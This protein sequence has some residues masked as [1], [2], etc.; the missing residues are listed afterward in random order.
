MGKRLVLLGVLVIGAVL[1]SGC[2]VFEQLIDQITGTGDPGGGTPP[3]GGGTPGT[4]G[5]VTSVSINY[6]F[7]VTMSER[8]M[9]TYPVTTS[10]R[11]LVME[12]F[13]PYGGSYDAATKTYTNT[14]DDQVGDFSDTYLEV[15]LNAAEDTIEYFYA[16]QTQENVWG[17][18]TFVN[19]IRG[20]NIPYSYTDSAAA[21]GA[22]YF[23]VTGTD[24]QLSLDR[25]IYKGVTRESEGYSIANPN[26]WAY[27]DYAANPVVDDVIPDGANNITIQVNQ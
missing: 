21:G 2:D 13:R 4:T 7:E 24:A 26:E 18:W 23:A 6:N 17:A 15:R 9:P 16:R 1:L 27:L 22:R 12:F 14:W 3:P 11:T 5:T 20:Y 19:E 10:Q 8:V 25:M